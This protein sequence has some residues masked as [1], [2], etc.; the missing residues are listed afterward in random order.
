MLVADLRYALSY[1]YRL[2]MIRK[3]ILAPRCIAF[4]IISSLSFLGQ[5]AA[6][7]TELVQVWSNTVATG[8]GGKITGVHL[9]I[10]QR[11]TY[12]TRDVV[13]RFGRRQFFSGLQTRGV[14]LGGYNQSERLA[15]MKRAELEARGLQPRVEQQSFPV[16]TLYVRSNAGMV[17]AINAETGQIKWSSRAGK[18]GYPSYSVAANDDHVVALSSTKLYLM[19]AATGQVLDTVSTLS[20][21]SGTPTLDGKYIYVP[22]WRGL[23]EVYSTDRFGRVEY[24]LG[25]TSPVVGSVT[26]SPEALGWACDKGDLYV[27]NR[28][29]PGMRFRFQST[30]SISSPPAYLDGYFFATSLGGFIYAIDETRGSVKWRHSAGGP[31]DES[32]LAVDGMVLA[33]TRNGQLVCLDADTGETK[34]RASGIQTF[35]SASENR[36]YCATTDSQLAI[37]DIATGI[38]VGTQRLGANNLPIANTATD[39]LYL[40]SHSGLIR[41]LREPSRRWPIIRQKDLAAPEKPAV[42][43]SS[44]AE[45]VGEEIDLSS[46]SADNDPAV[47]DTSD[48]LSAPDPTEEMDAEEEDPFGAFGEEPAADGGF[49]DGGD[50]GDGDEED[51]FGDL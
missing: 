11:D 16:T 20:I 15:D 39:R 28:R 1:L 48:E 49:S 32:P 24:T 38:R 26:L 44:D 25:S 45:E 7:D 40:T 31:I 4:F 19:D 18:E 12:E 9:H 34:W 2:A 21:P 41:C 8:L 46:P 37:L 13:D 36:L 10:S 6:Q 30:D 27:G 43:G 51:P 29:Q 17:T 50:M 23:I 33:T 14:S 35:V 5:A 22:T 47:Q 42:I 3:H